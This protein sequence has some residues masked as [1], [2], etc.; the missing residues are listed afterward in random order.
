MIEELTAGGV[1]TDYPDGQ[2]A[3]AKISEVEDGI[4]CAAWIRFGAAMA[5]DQHWSFAGDAGNFAGDKFIEDKIAD[6]ADSLARK[7]GYDVEQAG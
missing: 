3:C 1:V 6:Y 2:D 7:A 4:S 5:D